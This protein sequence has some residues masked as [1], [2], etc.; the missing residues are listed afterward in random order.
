MLFGLELRLSEFMKS[1]CCGG[2]GGNDIDVDCEDCGVAVGDSCGA[3][4]CPNDC[5]CAGC[6][7]GANGCGVG[8]GCC[9]SVMGVGAVG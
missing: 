9:E 8:E 2:V 1:Y 7:A 6:G 4:V 3:G 5:G